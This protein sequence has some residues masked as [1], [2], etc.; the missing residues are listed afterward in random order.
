[1]KIAKALATLILLLLMANHAQA[2]TF[3]FSEVLTGDTPNGTPPWLKATFE[4]ATAKVGTEDTRG[5]LLTLTAPGL[6]DTDNFVSAWA[7]NN[8][9]P[10]LAG[11]Q[12][13]VQQL[14][15]MT[16]LKS[17]SSGTDFYE[18]GAGARYDLAIVFLTSNAGSGAARFE[19]GELASLF[20]YGVEGLDAGSFYALS[21]P[22]GKAY[23]AEAHIQGIDGG[24]E[25]SSWVV[26][27]GAPV[28]EPGTVMLL[29]AGFL[30]LLIYS[31]RRRNA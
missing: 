29:G 8:Q 5:V 10:T 21:S 31:K 1:M 25:G 6:V 16:K 17:F 4:D 13:K 18:A 9:L 14:N 20:L 11:L 15:G 28:P 7:F 23:L 12:Y 3:E 19:G 26:P 24:P 2:L 30:G 22:S 27:G